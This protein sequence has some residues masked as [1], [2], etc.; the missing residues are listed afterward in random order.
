MIKCSYD[1]PIS[2]ENVCAFDSPSKT[3]N[4][5]GPCS[6]QNSFSFHQASPCIFVKFKKV[7]DWV[8]KNFNLSALPKDMPEDLQNVVKEINTRSPM[9]WV[10]CEAETP[11]DVENAGRIKYFPSRGFPTYFFPYTGQD[12]YLEPLIAVQL[13]NPAR[14]F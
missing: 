8:P 13:E 2:K 11:I 5:F 7:N 12:E 4:S 6:S 1:Q 3:S 9:V 14:K 10:S